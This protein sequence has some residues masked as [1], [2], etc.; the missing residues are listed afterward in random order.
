MF[1]NTLLS[2]VLSCFKVTTEGA[3]SVTVFRSYF[4]N[5]FLRW[6]HICSLTSGPQFRIYFPMYIHFQCTV[7]FC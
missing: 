4:G 3:G 2:K 5:T 7:N 1:Q 6:K